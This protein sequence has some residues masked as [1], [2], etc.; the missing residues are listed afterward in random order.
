MVRARLLPT[1]RPGG[2]F[3][4]VP[5]DRRA[6]PDD[7]KR[8]VHRQGRP[9]RL[10]DRRREAAHRRTRYRI[11]V[12]KHEGKPFFLYGEDEDGTCFCPE[13]FCGRS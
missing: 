4:Q 8:D 3:K 11:L 10:P 7:G 12:R 6:S 1:F 2:I 5:G 13:C 9:R